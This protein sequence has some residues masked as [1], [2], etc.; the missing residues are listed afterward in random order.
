MEEGEIA[1]IFPQLFNETQINVL[2]SYEVSQSFGVK[3]NDYIQLEFSRNQQSETVNAKVIGVYNDFPGFFATLPDNMFKKQGGIILDRAH[4]VRYLH[5]PGGENGYL[6]K[7]YLKVSSS[8]DPHEVYNRFIAYFS[9]Y[10]KFQLDTLHIFDFIFGNKSQEGLLVLARVLSFVL[11]IAIVSIVIIGFISSSYAVFI[12]RQREIIIY[13]A[14]GLNLQDLRKLFFYELLILLIGNSFIGSL[15]GM[16]ASYFFGNLTRM[17]FY[18]KSQFTLPF[19]LLALMLIICTALL[20]LFYKRLFEKKM[21]PQLLS[22]TS[23]F[24][25]VS[26]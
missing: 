26:E 5:L 1:K 9:Q 13:R 15:I 24:G 7:I 4:Y 8:A 20:Y 19:D 11:F 18:S 25:R 10:P 21:K 16:S 6:S 2:I 3:T 17:F 23:F 14:L 12:E 22:S